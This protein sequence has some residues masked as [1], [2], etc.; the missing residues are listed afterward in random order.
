MVWELAKI[1]QAEVR[2]TSKRIKS[3]KTAGPEDT[4]VE[5]RKC[6]GEE[7]VEFLARTVNKIFQRMSEEVC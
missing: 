2:K 7:A 4:P 1:S 3:R 5:V 6:L